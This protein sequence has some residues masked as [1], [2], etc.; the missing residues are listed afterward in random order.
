MWQL[1]APNLHIIVYLDLQKSTV[2]AWRDIP[3]SVRYSRNAI[4]NVAT[5]HLIIK[6]KRHLEIFDCVQEMMRI[7]SNMN[8]SDT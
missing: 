8:I 4:Q 3:T 7:M 2:L 6:G 5:W 1:V